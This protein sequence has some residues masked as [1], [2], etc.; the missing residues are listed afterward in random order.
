MEG[1]LYIGQVPL[2]TKRGMVYLILSRDVIPGTTDRV[3]VGAVRG[4]QMHETSL[5]VVELCRIP[6]RQRDALAAGGLP[7]VPHVED[8]RLR[9]GKCFAI[10]ELPR[11]G[12]DSSRALVDLHLDIGA[13]DGVKEG[14][15][16]EIQGDPFAD[17]INQIVTGFEPLGQCIVQSEVAEEHATCRLDKRQ[18][19]TFTRDRALTGGWAVFKARGR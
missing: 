14:D 2:G 16:Y 13:G 17:P 7:A 3:Q 12:W 5:E 15:R 18:W 1:K 19:P 10:Y 11:G 9:V 4:V 6:S 8:K